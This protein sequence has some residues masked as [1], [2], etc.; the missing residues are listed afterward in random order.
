L[1]F[2]YCRAILGSVQ[3]ETIKE[4]TLYQVEG[5]LNGKVEVFEWIVDDIGVSHRRFIANGKITGFP[6]QVP[7]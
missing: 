4:F 5:S 1:F 6:N 2:L 7:H 3:G